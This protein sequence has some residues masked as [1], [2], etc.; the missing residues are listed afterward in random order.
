[1]IDVIE[2]LPIDDEGHLVLV[3]EAILQERE[4]K[5]R[6]RTIEF[7]IRW[8]D[9]SEDDATW[10]GEKILHP[11][12]LYFLEGKQHLGVEDFHVPNK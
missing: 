1:V 6:S 2:L 9:L 12:T 8:M 5:I 11:P 3:L 10:D 7:L 4:R